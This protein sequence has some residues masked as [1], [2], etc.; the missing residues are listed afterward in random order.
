MFELCDKKECTS[1]MACYNAC[2]FNAIKINTDSLGTLIPVIDRQQC[3][4]C[5]KCVSVCP[6]VH[7]PEKHEANEAIA[8]YTKNSE[9]KK[10]CASGGV[11]TSLSRKIIQS[12]GVVFGTGF[13][14]EGTPVYK[15]AEAEEQLEEFKGSKYVYCFPGKIYCE[16]KQ[17]LKSGKLC[18]FIGTPCHV[19]GLKG[20]LGKEYENLITIDLICHGT[21]PY[22]YLKEYINQ[23]GISEKSISKV[24]FRGEK[25]F[26][27][28]IYNKEGKELYSKK[29]DE[30]VYFLSFMEGLIYRDICR[31]CS[32]AKKERI[33][34]ITIGDFWGIPKN[35]LNGYKGKI[36]VALPNTE[37]GI[38]ILEEYKDCFY[39]EKHSLEEAVSGNPQL[40]RPSLVHADTDLFKNEYM[41]T[42]NF[43]KSINATSIKKEVSK[44]IIMNKCLKIP[45]IIKHLMF[46]P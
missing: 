43:S 7:E 6:V 29:I 15:K 8:L 40:N 10:T 21:P 26:F 16:V 33:S 35:A 45:R 13:S 30:D 46:K 23:L 1:C 31:K 37:K 38:N 44:N 32:Y 25:D 12:G 24:S 17:E 41:R 2:S 14:N 20:Y 19:A 4:K 9:D 42:G 5:G 28:V 18:L 39:T 11:A 36:S 22:I 3:K 27:I 34:D